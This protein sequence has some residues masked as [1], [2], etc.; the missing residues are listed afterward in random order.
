MS[1]EVLAWLS[2]LNGSKKKYIF[3]KRDNDP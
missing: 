3:G 1:D 2:E